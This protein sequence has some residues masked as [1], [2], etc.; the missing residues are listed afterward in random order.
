MVPS[1]QD[2]APQASLIICSMFPFRHLIHSIKRSVV[3]PSPP[4]LIYPGILP[5]L[6]Y[7][8]A[9]GMFHEL[10]LLSCCCPELSPCQSSSASVKVSKTVS[11]PGFTLSCPFFSQVL[12]ES[13]H[14]HFACPVGKSEMLP[15]SCDD[16]KPRATKQGRDK[17]GTSSSPGL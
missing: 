3:C 13:F 11:I 12:E 1:A 15:V 10:S 14:S 6:M 8:V 9:S 7:S 5:F 2:L 4:W 16:R 17:G